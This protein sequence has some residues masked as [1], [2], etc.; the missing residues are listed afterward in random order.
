MSAPKWLTIA[1]E[2]SKT[3]IIIHHGWLYLCDFVNVRCV[4]DVPLKPFSQ[5]W[6]AWTRCIFTVPTCF[7]MWFESYTQIMIWHILCALAP[8]Y[9]FIFFR[10][11]S[12]TSGQWYNR[13][14]PT[15]HQTNIPQWLFC[16][17]N[18]HSCAHFCY[19][20][21]QYGIWDRCIVWFLR[22]VYCSC[23]TGAAIEKQS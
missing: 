8:V 14:S 15:I 3:L 1:H 9:P 22:I 7:T 21:V 5:F 13:S 23:A 6:I 19:K 20:V 12:P 10:I 2:S 17:R 4:W 11:T 18:V 16:N